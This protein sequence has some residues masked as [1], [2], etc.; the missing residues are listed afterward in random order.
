MEDYT[1]AA[2]APKKNNTV[3][4]VVI[5]IAVVLLCCCCCSLVLAWQYGDAILQQLDL[6]LRS[7]PRLL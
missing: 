1:P 7:L 6:T 4:I 5:V 2:E 3:L